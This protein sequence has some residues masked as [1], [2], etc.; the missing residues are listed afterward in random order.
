M[1]GGNGRRR[2]AA[3][4]ATGPGDLLA[5]AI[6]IAGVC[7]LFLFCTFFAVGVMRGAQFAMHYLKR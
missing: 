3:F 4:S 2:W 6:A 5:T 7:V 1:S